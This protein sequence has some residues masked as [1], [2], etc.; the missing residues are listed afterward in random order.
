MKK[1]LLELALDQ[2]NFEFESAYLYLNMAAWAD[3]AGYAGA[4]HWMEKQA[5]EE[6]EHGMKIMHFL[7]ELDETVVL[8][9]IG[10][11]KLEV[12]DYIDLF[13]QSLAHEKIVTERIGK[14]FSASMASQNYAMVRLMGW[15]VDEQAEEEA[16][17]NDIITRLEK[18]PTPIGIMRMDDSLAQR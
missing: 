15:F 16:T 5:S 11:D 10:L 2:I 3:D 1:E 6:M 12:A 18:V 9:P 14:L 8:K 4:K 17:L 13:K 7:Q